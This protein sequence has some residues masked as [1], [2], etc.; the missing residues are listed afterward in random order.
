MKSFRRGISLGTGCLS[1]AIRAQEAR[2]RRRDAVESDL[3]RLKNELT[4]RAELSPYSTQFPDWIQIVERA[5]SWVV[6]SR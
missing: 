3:E 1:N 4:Q 5:L 6:T 2:E